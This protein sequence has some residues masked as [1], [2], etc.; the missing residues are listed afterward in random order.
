MK[1][2]FID[3]T[4]ATIEGLTPASIGAAASSDIANLSA[5]IDN[6]NPSA[7]GLSNIAQNVNS[8]ILLNANTFV[9]GQLTA[10]AKLETRLSS[11]GL[12]IQPWAE[13]NCWSA[14]FDIWAENDDIEHEFSFFRNTF[15]TT[16]KAGIAIYRPDGTDSINHYFAAYGSSYVCRNNGYFGVGTNNPQDLMHIANGYLRC[17]YGLKLSSNLNRIEYAG[18]IPTSGTWSRGDIVF[19]NAP[20]AGGFVGWVCVAAGTPGTW[21][22]WG[23]I[24]T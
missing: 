20:S 19:N 15:G 14:R 18:S 16:G 22:T 10:F 23:A 12:N 3:G 7:I 2:K 8:E 4:S 13:S 24:S 21:K 5:R 11:H 9:D 6:L 17:D 1:L